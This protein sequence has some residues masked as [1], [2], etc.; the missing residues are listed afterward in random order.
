MNPS[1]D[2]NAIG[3]GGG[4]ESILKPPNPPTLV[5]T[6]RYVSL[7]SGNR[8][9]VAYPNRFDY[10]ITL[11]KEIMNVKTIKVVA[12]VVPNEINQRRYIENGSITHIENLRDYF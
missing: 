3:S 1:N 9:H 11:E 2:P 4:L 5:K 7:F 12:V 10:N 6:L 8:D